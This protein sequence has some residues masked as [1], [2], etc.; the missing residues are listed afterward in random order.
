M[1]VSSV[2]HSDSI[3]HIHISIF[4]FRLFSIIGYYKILS[5][6]PCAVQQGLVVYLVYIQSCV[7][8]NPKLLHI[9]FYLEVGRK[10]LTNFPGSHLSDNSTA[11]LAVRG[12]L[13]NKTKQN[14]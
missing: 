11:R 1:L 9:A 8:V 7:S 6:V 13:K 12:N 14:K 4:F 5:R 2:Q 3:T 10:F